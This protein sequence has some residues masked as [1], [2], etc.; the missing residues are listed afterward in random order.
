METAVISSCIYTPD[1]LDNLLQI[2]GSVAAFTPFRR[3]ISRQAV[4]SFD[5]ATRTF[6]IFHYRPRRFSIGAGETTF[7][8]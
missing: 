5:F 7:M 6:T 1:L 2:S 8:Q 4:G 3:I